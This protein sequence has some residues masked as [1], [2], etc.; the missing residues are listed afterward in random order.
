[1]IVTISSGLQYTIMPIQRVSSYMIY[2][3]DVLLLNKIDTDTGIL[4]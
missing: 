4:L 1:M 2:L 3:S